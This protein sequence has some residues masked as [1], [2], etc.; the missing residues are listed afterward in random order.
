MPKNKQTNKSTNKTKQITF[1]ANLSS[2]LTER[3]SI[4]WWSTKKIFVPENIC[5]HYILTEQINGQTFKRQIHSEAVYTLVCHEVWS[6]CLN[7]LLNF[8]TVFLIKVHAVDV[9]GFIALKVQTI[10]TKI[11]SINASWKP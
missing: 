5:I 4:N 10:G 2:L 6:F 11:E 9:T 8:E 1:R 7:W 3:V